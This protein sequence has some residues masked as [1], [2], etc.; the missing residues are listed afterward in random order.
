MTDDDKERLVKIMAFG[1][2]ESKW[3]TKKP[4]IEYEEEIEEPEEID[5]F[6]ECNFKNLNINLNE[7][8]AIKTNIF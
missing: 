7:K 5:R 4:S 3:P 8:D 1:N 2:D 6:D